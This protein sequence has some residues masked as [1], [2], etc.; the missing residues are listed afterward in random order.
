MLFQVPKHFVVQQIIQAALMA[1]Q[2]VVALESTV[3][4]HGL[5]YPENLKLAKEM[6]L[7]ITEGNARPATIAVLQGKVRVGLDTEGLEI[8]AQGRSTRKI[9]VRDFA[10][11]IVQKASGGTTVAGTLVVAE[12]VGIKIFATGG[13]GGVHRE[14]PFDISTDLQQLAKSK[15]VV[16]CAGAK[17]IL[18]L[19]ATLEKLETLGVP[20]LGYQTGEFPAFY[21]PES[22]LKVSARVDSARE[23]AEI[24]KA[25]WDMGGGGLLVAVPIPKEEA[26]PFQEMESFIEQALSEAKNEHIQGQAVTPFLLK[27]V[28]ELSGGKSLKAN[29]ALL[30]NNARTAAE[31]AQH[32]YRS[33]TTRL[34]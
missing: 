2:P 30:K 26:I 12:R 15:V 18:D 9:S 6:E 13:I 28:T 14:T 10:P 3:I 32:L 4:S 31:I 8:L 19:P 22:G 27:R 17:S 34:A 16:V 29:L 1:G 23:A 33:K 7:I 24:A 20:V 11:A 21:S 5:P 25:H